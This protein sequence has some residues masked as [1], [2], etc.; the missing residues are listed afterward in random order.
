MSRADSD[1]VVRLLTAPNPIV[2]HV[3]QSALAAEGIRAT[4]VGDYLDASFGDLPGLKPELWVHRKDVARAEEILQHQVVGEEHEE[5]AAE[6][7]EP[8]PGGP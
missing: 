4:V 7:E 5:E 1:E 3:W 6:A 2:A 8:E